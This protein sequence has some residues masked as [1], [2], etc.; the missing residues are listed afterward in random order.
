MMKTFAL[1]AALLVATACGSAGAPSSAT[2]A[3]SRPATV[4]ATAAATNTPQHSMSPAEM[5]AMYASPSAS[6]SA[7]TQATTTPIA[8]SQPAPQGST[9]PT[10]VP[11]ATAAPIASAAATTSPATSAPAPTTA[12]ASGPSTTVNV[13]L[14]DAAIKLS[15]LGVAPGKVTF[16]VTNTGAVEHEFVILQTSLPQNAIPVDPTNAALVQEPG[17]IGK[18]AALAPKTSGSITLSLATGSYVLICNELA[19]YMALGMHTGFSVR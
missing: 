6:A 19:H 9:A 14:T 8:T 17:L 16:Q 4:N 11:N 1:G 5:A 10:A 18:V 2:N 7:Q 12:V 3:P 13:T 15:T